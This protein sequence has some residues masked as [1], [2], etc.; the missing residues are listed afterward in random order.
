MA[1]YT[2]DGKTL[3]KTSTGQ[4]MGEA[5]RTSVRSWNS[6]RLG[7]IQGKNIR[8]THGKKVLEFDGKNVKDDAGAKVTTIKDIQKV[9]EGEPSIYLVAAWHF[10]VKGQQ[11]NMT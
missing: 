2:F 10:L 6:A 4:K 9:I 3:R 11:S 8:D 1:D 5:D 7:E